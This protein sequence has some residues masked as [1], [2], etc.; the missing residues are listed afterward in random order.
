[1]NKTWR[2]IL[3]A[4]LCILFFASPAWAAS[5]VSLADWY[6]NISVSNIGGAAT[7]VSSN[8]TGMTTASLISGG[9]LNAT[10]TNWAIRNTAG[11]DA[12][13]MPGYG[14]NPWCIYT[15][16]LG[17][18][19]MINYL[20]YI[21]N[22][23]GYT[24]YWFSGSSGGTIPDTMVEPG[25]QF[26]WT[27]TDALIDT[28]NGTSKDIINKTGAY[29]LYVDSTTS[30]KLE[31]S[32][33]EQGHPILGGTYDATTAG[34][35]EYNGIMGGKDWNVTEANVYHV[36]PTAGV[37]KYLNIRL[38]NAPT[39]GQQIAFTIMKNGVPQTLTCTVSGTN[40]VAS[41][42]VNTVSYVAGDR[43]SIKY[44]AS[45]AATVTRVSWSTFFIP[46]TAEETIFTGNSLLSNA[47]TTYLPVQGSWDANAT[48]SYVS[49]VAPCAG[50]I[51][52]FYVN[53]SVAPG[54]GNYVLTLRKNGVDTTVV[55]TVTNPAT[56]AS[57]TT[58]SFTVAAGDYITIK[59]VDTGA[60][61]NPNCGFG[62]KFIPSVANTSVI[63]IAGESIGG[64][65]Y[66]SL[67]TADIN[68]GVSQ[69]RVAEAQ[70][71]S[72]QENICSISNMYVRLT[73]A[74]G[75]VTSWDFKLR[76]NAV[77]TALVVNIT[78]AATSGS[79]TTHTATI[80]S[81]DLL[82]IMADATGIPAGTYA[83]V[84]LVITTDYTNVS[85]S[86]ITT[87]EYDIEL[88]LSGGTLSLTVGAS[89]NSTAY[90]G[91]IKDNASSTVLCEGDTVNYVKS[92]T[93]EQGG[94]LVDNWQW[95]YA[96]IFTGDTTGN[97]LT[98]SFRTDSTDVD[99]T[100][101]FGPIL[102]ITESIAPAFAVGEGPDFLTDNITIEGTPYS[103]NASGVLDFPG[104]DIIED[105]AGITPK[106]MIYIFISSF[107]LLAISLI[108]SHFLK[109]SGASS[110]FIKSV[111]NIIV[112][113]ILI[114]LHIFDW[115]MLIFYFIF[116]QSIW[117]A[118]KER[119]E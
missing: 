73:T 25:N 29:S 68:G 115:W 90:T 119:R 47:F 22:V 92:I 86:G 15:G 77:S 71:Y 36:M 40:T 100:G 6:A 9:Y 88:E 62:F 46:T 23:T 99:V 60:A 21:K 17:P 108:V 24:P 112:Y 1:M 13:A 27:L 78:G 95:E 82:D 98:P 32:S 35:T 96:A 33:G 12:P 3:A 49:C 104:K 97:I 55:C 116:E 39:A 2:S 70:A 45:A 114:A 53:F 79:D 51:S 80:A 106:Q 69:W 52:D 93:Y 19:S 28:S 48:E 107:I 8:I 83:M 43:I 63:M 84:S 65:V 94:A 38:Q 41:D 37:I 91:T 74:P 34:A 56:S 87:G 42:D 110:I 54:A 31:A 66:H 30:G 109:E 16:N 20:L 89:S 113:G 103:A 14:T 59:S 7:Y 72:T 10:A 57:D 105:I 61:A 64:D 81:L 102:P 4:I 58:H 67:G 5:D 76:D 85:V 117:F 18:N 11:G 111:A 118:A 44:V 26:K 50:T 75:G 101:V